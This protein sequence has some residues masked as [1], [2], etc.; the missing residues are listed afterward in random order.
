MIDV[1]E[2]RKIL[3]EEKYKHYKLTKEDLLQII[4]EEGGVRMSDIVKRSRKREIVNAR[5]IYCAILKDHFNY[6]LVRIGDEIDGRDHTSVRHAITEF[7]NRLYTEDNFK[8]LVQ[9][10]YSRIGLKTS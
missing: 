6:T 7:R 8:S 2:K 3:T 10:I 9:N 4:A 5:F 1:K